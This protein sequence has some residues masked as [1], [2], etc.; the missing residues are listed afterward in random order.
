MSTNPKP[1]KVTSPFTKEELNH[2][3]VELDIHDVEYPL[4]GVWT[5]ESWTHPDGDGIFVAALSDF[6]SEFP[7]FRQPNAINRPTVCFPQ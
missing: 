7:Q 3:K 6:G 4:T 2:K 5:F 1:H